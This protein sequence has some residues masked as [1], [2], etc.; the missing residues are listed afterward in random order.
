MSF[1][2]FVLTLSFILASTTTASHDSSPTREGPFSLTYFE[3]GNGGGSGWTAKN[4]LKISHSIY[5]SSYSTPSTRL[6]PKPRLVSVAILAPPKYNKK[7]F[8]E[9]LNGRVDKP[10]KPAKYLTKPIRS[11]VNHVTGYYVPVRVY[12]PK[13]A[14]QIMPFIQE[15]NFYYLI[16]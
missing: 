11:T 12:T 10:Y 7:Y 16:I 3:T 1:V 13:V 9:H 6:K 14:P 8:D 15:V 5:D 4:P 2:F